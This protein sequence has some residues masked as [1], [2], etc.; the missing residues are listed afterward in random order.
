MVDCFFL[1]EELGLLPKA[2]SVRVFIGHLLWL[3]GGVPRY[4]ARLVHCIAVKAGV[5]DSEYFTTDG[6]PSM[7]NYVESMKHQHFQDVLSKWLVTCSLAMK[8]TLPD[9]DVLND[10]VSLCISEIPVAARRDCKLDSGN[11][12]TIGSAMQCELLHFGTDGRIVVPP[13][14]LSQFCNHSENSDS[15][16]TIVLKNLD[17]VLS[18]RDNESL[19]LSV[20]LHRLKSAQTLDIKTVKLSETFGVELK[21]DHCVLINAK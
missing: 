3:A 14:L 16:R 13:L 8:V 2:M 21:T 10:I 17:G 15:C 20:V 9:E 1:C 6:R 19:Y 5:A 12:C 11:T 7:L 4:I 18:H